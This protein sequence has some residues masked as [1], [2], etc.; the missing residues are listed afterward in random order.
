VMIAGYIWLLFLRPGRDVE[1]A[2]GPG[3]AFASTLPLLAAFAVLVM[4]WLQWQV[5]GKAGL[6]FSEE[7]IA[8][9]FPA[10]ITRKQLIHYRLLYNL[11]TTMVSALVF[12]LIFNGSRLGIES[13][14]RNW[15]AWWV[16]QAVLGF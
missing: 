7:E 10:P 6:R 8:F 15:G 5:P 14:L 9:L 3:N 4:M 1:R 16:I 2:F 13:A 12:M 11:A